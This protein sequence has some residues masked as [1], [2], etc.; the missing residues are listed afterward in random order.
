MLA[1]AAGA[2]AASVRARRHASSLQ[3]VVGDDAGDEADLQRFRGVDDR[4]QHQD[5]H[6][7][8]EADELRQRHADA[9]V[10]DHRDPRRSGD[11]FRRLRGDDEIR[12]ADQPHAAAARRIALHGSHDR[13]L[14]ADE[15]GRDQ[16]QMRGGDADIGR[17]RL[18]LGEESV[19]VA[20]GAEIRA[21]AAQ[22]HHAHAIVAMQQH[23]DALKLRQ[24]FDIEPVGGLRPVEPHMGDAVGVEIGEHRPARAQRGHRRRVC[25]RP[26][27]N[28]VSSVRAR[29]ELC[30]QLID[31]LA[32]LCQSRR[33]ARAVTRTHMRLATS[34]SITSVAPPPMVR[35]R[36]SRTMRSIGVPT[37]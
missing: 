2:P 6:R 31:R 21:L 10:G 3:R 18:A 12:G 29:R 5:F 1:S 36:A 34:S 32:G 37:I 25:H 33:Y 11:E 30:G 35:M 24:Q 15:P 22:Q 20:A 19:D 14:Q 23:D 7:P 26:T 13:R 8:P 16:P 9:G 17:Q 4:V 27:P 28:R